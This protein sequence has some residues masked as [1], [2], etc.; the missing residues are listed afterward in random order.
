MIT[1][2][3]IS[4]AAAIGLAGTIVLLIKRARRLKAENVSQANTIDRLEHIVRRQQEVAREATEARE[5]ITTGTDRERFDASLDIL[6]DGADASRS[7][8]HD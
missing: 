8:D 2:A 5:K 7:R 3:V 4:T 6:S 1:Y